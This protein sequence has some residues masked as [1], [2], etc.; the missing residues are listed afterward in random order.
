MVP[1]R[2][3]GCHLRQ[4]AYAAGYLGKI[5]N[6]LADLDDADGQ[7]DILGHDITTVE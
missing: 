4:H 1:C 6:G 7:I 2:R 5:T 3:D